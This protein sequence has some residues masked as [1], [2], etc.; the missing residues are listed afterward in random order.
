MFQ[1]PPPRFTQRRVVGNQ[2]EQT[3]PHPTDKRHGALPADAHPDDPHRGALSGG[4]RTDGSG[5]YG[6]FVPDRP[7]EPGLEP[8]DPARSASGGSVPPEATGPG[9]SERRARHPGTS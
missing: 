9:G 8:Y 7:H 5:S 1:N 4:T 3:E 6:D 2:P